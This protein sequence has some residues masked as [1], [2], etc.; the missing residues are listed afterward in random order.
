MPRRPSARR[1]ASALFQLALEAGDVQ[2]WQTDLQTLDEALQERE[3]VAFLGM[4]K[5]RLAQKMQ[6][7]EEAL[8]QLSILARNLMGLLISRRSVDILP[9]IKEEYAHL[10]DQHGGR[11]RASV[12]S[13]VPLDQSQR[14]R[15]VKYLGGLT[16]AEI[17][18]SESVDPALLGGLVAR[19]GDRIVDGSTR[20]RLLDLRKSLAEA[21]L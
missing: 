12:V 6:V 2:V 16:G 14:E 1:Y 17:L 8:P 15:L 19:V 10:L 18:L 7:V 21:A 3:F 5:I 11:V 9:S 4:P 20:T 13:A